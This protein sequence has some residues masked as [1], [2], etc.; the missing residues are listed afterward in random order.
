MR[1]AAIRSL[2]NLAEAIA[3]FQIA[4]QLRPTAEL[5]KKLEDAKAK[6][7]RQDYLAEVAKAEK[8]RKDK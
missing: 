7:A 5:D 1:A 3:K 2:S 4:I 6:K 8:A